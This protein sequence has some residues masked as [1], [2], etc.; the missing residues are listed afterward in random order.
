MKVR[1]C[2]P[3]A[4]LALAACSSPTVPD[5][6]WYRLPPAAPL[7]AMPAPR[8]EL[9]EVEAFA[10]DGL[11]ADTALVYAL[12]PQ[13]QQLRQYHYQV[14]ADPPT[15]FLQRRLIA[16]LRGTGWARE[17]TDELPASRG[18]LRI[19]GVL[20]RMDRV[21]QAEAGWQVEVA[22][23][24]QATTA[25]GESLVNARYVESEPAIGKEL[26]ASVDAYGAAIDRVFARFYAD[27][28]KS[29]VSVHD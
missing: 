2:L 23:K 20:L 5:F 29:E 19:Q 9:V 25:S 12:D 11:Y 17:V 16:A 24:L 14:W 22:L 1:S 6:T 28:R 10:A 3:I 7:E 26:K 13:A 21:P 4:L 18:A 8:H 15:R 27:L